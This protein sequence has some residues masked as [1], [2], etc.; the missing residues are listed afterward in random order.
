MPERTSA[1]IARS[2][3]ANV[4][5]ETCRDKPIDHRRVACNDLIFWI[6]YWMRQSELRF[7]VHDCLFH[8]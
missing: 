1:S 7:H 8:C 5:R 4:D 3:H 6:K 2:L